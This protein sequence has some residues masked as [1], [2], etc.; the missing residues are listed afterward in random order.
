MT[1]IGRLAGLLETELKKHRAVLARHEERQTAFADLEDERA[2]Y[3][4]LSFFAKTYDVNAVGH[5]ISVTK[6]PTVL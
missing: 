1:D 6:S 2:V 5:T 4:L 3:H